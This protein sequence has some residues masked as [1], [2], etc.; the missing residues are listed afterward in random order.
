ML[1]KG[2]G[3]CKNTI[4]IISD[5]VGKLV[6]HSWGHYFKGSRTEVS[7]E[8]GISSLLV[9]RLA[10]H[11]IGKRQ[12]QGGQYQWLWTNGLER[13]RGRLN[14]LLPQCYER[15]WGDIRRTWKAL[16]LSSSVQPWRTNYFMQSL[17]VQVPS[18]LCQ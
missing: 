2:V 18:S 8:K 13:Q 7:W 12:N 3:H 1:C 10:I 4:N 9:S 15:R 16:P 6:L 17:W 14:I 11:W 5:C